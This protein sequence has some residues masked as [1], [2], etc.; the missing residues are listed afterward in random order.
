MRKK[1]VISGQNWGFDG[2]TI[3][4]HIPMTWKRRGGRK[5]II[6]PDGGDAWVSAKARPNE[7]LIRAGAG[8]SVEEDVGGGEVS[9]G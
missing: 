5:M 9:V 2:K 8:A 7:T 3:T 1:Q 4:V 6:A